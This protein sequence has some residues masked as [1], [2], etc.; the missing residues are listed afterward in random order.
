MLVGCGGLLPE[1]G[2]VQNAG[3][4]W[5]VS[6]PCC[7]REGEAGGGVRRPYCQSA[8]LP[9]Y[10][11]IS[12]DRRQWQ[13]AAAPTRRTVGASSSYLQLAETRQHLVAVSL[14]QSRLSLHFNFTSTNHGK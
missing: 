12:S 13:S 5:V 9:L 3:E 10:G 7:G 8:V 1:K 6:L 4:K 11:T 14:F 2:E